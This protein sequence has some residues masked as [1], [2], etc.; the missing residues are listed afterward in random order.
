MTLPLKDEV[1]QCVVLRKKNDIVI[2][3]CHRVL[4]ISPYSYVFITGKSTH[5]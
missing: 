2:V 5:S 4:E 3:C 1:N